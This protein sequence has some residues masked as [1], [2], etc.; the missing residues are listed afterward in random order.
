M[1][2]TWQG[3]SVCCLSMDMDG[4]F[5]I[6]PM[7]M[8]TTENPVPNTRNEKDHGIFLLCLKP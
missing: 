2:L 6:L 1:A 8:I 3:T 4:A 7:L 5:Y